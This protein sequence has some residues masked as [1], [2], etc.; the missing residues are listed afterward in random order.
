ML[1][2]MSKTYKHQATWDYLNG[3]PIGK[4]LWGIL[5][6]FIKCNFPKWDYSRKSCYKHK[7]RRL[8]ND[9]TEVYNR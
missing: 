5:R 4:Y 1:I 3:K 7:N 6:Y 9:T 2:K 8:N